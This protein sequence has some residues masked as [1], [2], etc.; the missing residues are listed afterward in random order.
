[1]PA[2]QPE[3]GYDH[4]EDPDHGHEHGGDGEEVQKR[5]AGNDR[6]GRAH[7]SLDQQVDEPDEQSEDEESEYDESGG[8]EPCAQQSDTGQ[9]R[10]QRGP[11]DEAGE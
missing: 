7:G 2:A 9:K 1:M 11:A 4:H 6:G 10:A 3:V 8:T 5:G